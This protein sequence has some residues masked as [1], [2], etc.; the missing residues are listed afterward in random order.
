MYGVCEN[1][2]CWKLFPERITDVSIAAFLLHQCPDPPLEVDSDIPIQMMNKKTISTNMLQHPSS[3][4]RIMPI[5][6]LHDRGLRPTEVRPLPLPLPALMF[7]YIIT[8]T[9]SGDT[10][11]ISEKQ[12][13]RLQQQSMVM[14][15]YCGMWDDV[16][17]CWDSDSLKK[18]CP[19]NCD[20]V[21]TLFGMR[22]KIFTYI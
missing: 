9:V 2:V 4:F 16:W 22:T 17:I 7:Q 10:L 8:C 6:W 5:C 21:L 14:T 20:N 19:S 13:S 11:E 15:Q 18:K 3:K 1:I 12:R